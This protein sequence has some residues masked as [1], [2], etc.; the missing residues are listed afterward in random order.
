MIFLL[1]VAWFCGT[2]TLFVASVAE[3]FDL[4]CQIRVHECLLADRLMLGSVACACVFPL[5][6][7]LTCA[8]TGRRI[9]A[10]VFLVLGVSVALVYGLTFGAGAVRDAH[11]LAPPASV[12]VP[13]DKCPCYSGGGCDCPGG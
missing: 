13:P 8:F 2:I 1:T 5:L 7:A 6:A 12:P 11:R 3:S 4:D 9:G 10:V